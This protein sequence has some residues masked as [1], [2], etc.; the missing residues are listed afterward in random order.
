MKFIKQTSNSWI[1][2]SSIKM[3][4][5]FM[6]LFAKNTDCDRNASHVA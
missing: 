6:S 1:Q 3:K 5:S 2:F 4:S